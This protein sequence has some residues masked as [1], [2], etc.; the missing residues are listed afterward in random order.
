MK[1]DKL[2]SI[3]MVG[4]SES[5]IVSSRNQSLS[6]VSPV[7]YEICNGNILLRENITR[8]KTSEKVIS[9]NKTASS[10]NKE[11]VRGVSKKAQRIETYP[12]EEQRLTASAMAKTRKLSRST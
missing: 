12:D 5:S 10:H 1:T 6:F 7:L 8:N 9:A 2:R 3:S 11:L 4:W